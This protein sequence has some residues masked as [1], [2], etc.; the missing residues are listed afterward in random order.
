MAGLGTENEDMKFRRRT[1]QQRDILRTLMLS[2]SLTAVLALG[3]L[4]ASAQTTTSTTCAPAAATAT[5]TTS[6][7]HPGVLTT[8]AAA[9]KG[10]STAAMAQEACQRQRA[11]TAKFVNC[12][13]PEAFG[14]EEPFTFDPAKPCS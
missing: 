2:A 11:R 5:P 3:A 1:M 6:N 13:V 10:T 9:P 7:A 4:S 14:S 8:A 12:G